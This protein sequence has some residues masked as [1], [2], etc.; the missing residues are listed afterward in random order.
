MATERNHAAIRHVRTLFD[1]GT[2]GS[3][4]DPQLLERFLTRNGEAAEL[5]FAALV[6]RH[7]PMVLRVC[8][9]V[10]TDPD[11]AHDA[12]QATFLV[13]ATKAG[14]L[15]RRD[16]LASWLHGVAIRVARC[17]RAASARRRVHEFRKA[18]AGSIVFETEEDDLGPIVHQEFARLPERYRAPMALCDMEDLT[19]EQA[20]R[21]LGL[22]VGTV[23]SRLARGRARLRDR[24]TRR[25][26]APTSIATMLMPRLDLGSLLP[27]AV[28]DPLARKAVQF[29]ASRST[30]GVVPASTSALVQGVRRM[31]VK[32]SI[33]CWTLTSLAI[34]VIV[35]GVALAA[36]SPA[37]PPSIP[38][39]K[40]LQTSAPGGEE[41][42]ISCEV[43]FV[44]MDTLGWRET[45][46]ARLRAVS[47]QGPCTVWTTDKKGLYEL[48]TYCQTAQGANVVQ[49]PKVTTFEGAPA[50]IYNT[51]RTVLVPSEAR[52]ADGSALLYP[53]RANF[54]A[55]IGDS[56]VDPAAKQ[57]ANG[58]DPFINR[59]VDGVTV[60]MT[61]KRAEKG[62]LV[63]GTITKSQ[64]V[65]LHDVT[66][67][68]WSPDPN[69]ADA[70]RSPVRVKLP[71]VV[72]SKVEGEWLLDDDTSLVVSL[73]LQR[74]VNERSIGKIGELLV[75]INA[76]RIILESEE[77]RLGAPTRAIVPNPAKGSPRT[78]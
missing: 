33:R 31:M 2:M 39:P 52:I 28:V 53:L 48:L 7:G 9:R 43:R 13:L 26:L 15:R 18:A 54:S 20:A 4:G 32:E 22:P 41:R 70:A 75:V 77:E 17:S 66:L 46:T 10:L 51:Q 44:A 27:D 74:N 5:A 78:P 65:A 69:R 61:G 14:S 3:L 55:Y 42:Q 21:Q 8:R 23:K 62:I 38:V 12:F 40:P 58:P 30:A 6:E 35:V 16:S 37:T 25:G 50:T 45:A 57:A 56:K 34:G 72:E 71:E 47:L 59:V 11:D 36:Q 68:G 1:V 76:R 60:R 19:H 67:P 29:A 73:G 24:L 63:Q 64:I 49:A